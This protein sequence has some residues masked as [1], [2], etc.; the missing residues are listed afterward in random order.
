MFLGLQ[1]QIDAERRRQQV[2]KVASA[3][4]EKLLT[5]KA[6]VSTTPRLTML[7]LML[8]PLPLSSFLHCSYSHSSSGARM[9]W[10]GLCGR[11]SLVFLCT[12]TVMSGPRFVPSASLSWEHG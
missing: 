12:A 8:Q 2:N 4:L 1:R 5:K 6:G 10:K 11:Y 9:S 7:S 3:K